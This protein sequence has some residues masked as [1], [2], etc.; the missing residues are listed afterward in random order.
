MAL[1]WTVWPPCCGGGAG[2]VAI[3]A[4][5]GL[6][7]TWMFPGPAFARGYRARPSPDCPGAG[8]H[9]FVP[10]SLRSRSIAPAAKVLPVDVSVSEKNAPVPPMASAEPA[11]TMTNN[12][13]IILFIGPEVHGFSGCERRLRRDVYCLPYVLPCWVEVFT[14]AFSDVCQV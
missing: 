7:A 5:A 12:P 10:K 2:Y 11:A 14:N 9:A 3:S 6:R 8:L 4:P 13:I 1:W